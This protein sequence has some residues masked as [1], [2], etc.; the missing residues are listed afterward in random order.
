M[1]NP[2]RVLLQFRITNAAHVPTQ[3]RAVEAQTPE[4]PVMHR[5]APTGREF[6]LKTEGVGLG[7]WHETISRAGYVLADAYCLCKQVPEH[8]RRTD[9][10]VLARF[11]YVRSDVQ[12]GPEDTNSWRECLL[13]M[14]TTALWTVQGHDNPCIEEGQLIE[15]ERCVSI[16]ASGRDQLTEPDG[17]LRQ[18][19]RKDANGKQYG[20]PMPMVPNY[21]LLVGGGG[22]PALMLYEDTVN[23]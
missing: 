9:T 19:R 23:V 12:A 21:L 14:A 22:K 10:S 1:A 20:L 2:K 7:R 16:T 3:L 6:I 13:D 18:R 15:G 4:T 8:H 5:P 17:S 11:V